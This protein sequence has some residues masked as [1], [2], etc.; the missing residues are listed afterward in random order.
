MSAPTG[1]RKP[2]RIKVYTQVLSVTNLLS[3]RHPMFIDTPQDT[4]MIR[5]IQRRDHSIANLQQFWSPKFWF[6]SRFAF[7]ETKKKNMPSGDIIIFFKTLITK[8]SGIITTS[9]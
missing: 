7:A 9:I 2:F 3:S 1:I 5:R 8:L 4:G 6:S